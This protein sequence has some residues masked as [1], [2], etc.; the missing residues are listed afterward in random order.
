MQT[1]QIGWT[2]IFADY[3]MDG[4]EVVVVRVYHEDTTFTDEN[5]IA[6]AKSTIVAMRD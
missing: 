3:Y 4:T 6:V 5:L 1:M 2:G